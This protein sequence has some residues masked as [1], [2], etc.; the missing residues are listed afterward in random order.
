MKKNK[1][2][3]SALAMTGGVMIAGTSAAA[4][5][6]GEVTPELRSAREVMDEARESSAARLKPAELLVAQ[7]TLERAEAASDGSPVEAD[8]AYVAE[9]E[10]Q[11][12][13]A[14]ARQAELEQSM[15]EDQ[16]RYRAGLET[17]AAERGQTI[18]ERERALMQQRQTLG[19]RERDLQERDQQIAQTREELAAE[20]QARQQAEQAAADAMTRLQ[21]LAAVRQERDHTVITLSGEV[22]FESD[23]AE[24]RASARERLLALADALRTEETQMATIEGHTDSRGSDDYNRRLSQRRAESVRD[25]LIA[26]GVPAARLQAVGRGESTPI[27]SNDDAEGRANNRR[28]EVHLRPL[29][30]PP[31]GAQPQR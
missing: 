21:E 2:I 22:L 18:E 3:L 24:L 15:R 10:A 8:M 19:E 16:Q 4:C 26:E 7:R 1:N 5:A 27:A 31:Q 11:I 25:Y 29:P 12:A 6:G 30:V 14:L 9:R 28:V 20:Q 23:Q 13:M 17:L